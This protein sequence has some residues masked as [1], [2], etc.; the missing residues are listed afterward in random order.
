MQMPDPDYKAVLKWLRR[1]S[2]QFPRAEAMRQAIGQ[3]LK[4]HWADRVGGHVDPGAEDWR[5]VDTLT[6]QILAEVPFYPSQLEITGGDIAKSLGAG[7][8][9]RLFQADL[10]TRIQSGQLENKRESLMNALTARAK[11]RE[12]R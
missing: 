8:Q 7:E 5:A 1:L 2:Q 10:L 3:L 4:L 12:E 6:T 9:V 11:R